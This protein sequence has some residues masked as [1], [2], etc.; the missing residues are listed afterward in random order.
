MDAEIRPG[1][2]TSGVVHA[3]EGLRPW[4]ESFPEARFLCTGMKLLAAPKGIGDGSHAELQLERDGEAVR[5]LAWR[6]M[7]HLTHLEAGT[8]VDV[9]FHP[10][11]NRFRG[12]SSV[13]W[14]LEDL[15]TVEG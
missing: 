10:G 13:E 14:T 11:I 9:V 6:M 3:L 1:D 15:R 5:V 12:R 2:L 7:D 4:G 8:Q